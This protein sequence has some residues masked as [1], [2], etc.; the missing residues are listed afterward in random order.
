[1][2][3][4]TVACQAP[5]SMEFPRQEYWSGLLFLQGIF[6]AQG[7]NLCLLHW[8]AGS[9][10]LSQGNLGLWS[11]LANWHC[12]LY[13]KYR[14]VLFRLPNILSLLF[15]FLSFV[16][17]YFKVK[18]ISK[19][20]DINILAVSSP[21]S[22]RELRARLARAVRSGAASSAEVR[23]LDS[24][25]LLLFLFRYLSM[26]SLPCAEPHIF[27]STS[28]SC[29]WPAPTPASCCSAQGPWI[30]PARRGC[31]RRAP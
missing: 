24:Q 31:K 20:L 23:Q 2:T 16:V 1:M 27:L 30:P 19:P 11:S 13:L 25:N 15:F 26:K 17:I 7:L 28:H 3:P 21:T 29:C 6:P 10:L 5:L 8:Q 22:Q 18:S 9:L 14:F 4:W 12:G